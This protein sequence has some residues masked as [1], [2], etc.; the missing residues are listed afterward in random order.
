LQ[1][2]A[3]RWSDDGAQEHIVEMRREPRVKFCVSEH[4]STH[5]YLETRFALAI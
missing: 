4:G 3:I 5:D 2:R 1:K